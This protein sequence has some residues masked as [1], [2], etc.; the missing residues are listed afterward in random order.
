MDLSII[1]VSYNTRDMLKACLVSVYGETRGIEFEV[2]V[3]DNASTDGSVEMVR[4][5]FPQARIIANTRNAG[6]AGGNNQGMAASHG[7]FFLLL[8]PDTVILDKAITKT[9]AFIRERKDIGVAG[10]RVWDADGSPQYTTFMYPRLVNMLLSATG[11]ASVFRKNRFFGRAQMHWWDH[12]DTREVEVV[13]GC[14]MLV[15]RVVYEQLGGMDERFFMYAEETDWC[16]RMSRAGWKIVF[17]HEAEIVHLI[18]Q[19]GAAAAR[20]M[21]IE[22][23]KSMVK[24]YAKNRGALA[25]WVANAIFV[26][27]DSVRLLAWGL[28][29]L[30]TRAV[31]RDSLALRSKVNAC[32]KALSYHLMGVEGGTGVS[33]TWKRQMTVTAT[34]ALSLLYYVLWLYP[35][36]LLLRILGIP[37][38]ELVILYYH[39]VLPWERAAFARQMDMLLA[40]GQPVALD[41]SE[42]VASHSLALAVTFDDAFENILDSAL[43]ELAARGIPATIFVPSASLGQTAVWQMRDGSPDRTEFIMT[44]DEV[45]QAAGSLISIGSHTLTHQRLAELGDDEA[46][47]QLAQSRA[48]L[49]TLLGSPVRTV[50][51][52]HGS[53]SPRTLELARE[54][55]YTRAYSI[56]LATARIAGDEFLRGRFWGDVDGRSIE[57][58]LKVR[59][60]FSWLWRLQRVKRSLAASRARRGQPPGEAKL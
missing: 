3:V 36:R 33:H 7:D 42:C 15:R 23:R 5:D 21:R 28:K 46:S 54:A 49:E 26:F 56:E 27:G 58:W 44:A 60:A 55:G 51:F 32:L 24:Y 9:L 47:R 34:T 41:V 4:F 6:F 1:I 12:N 57:H 29:F 52:P 2:I 35:K 20:D 13:A 50:A 25:A 11:L 17:Y 31:G 19:S 40:A 8:N 39:G 45:R 14:F 48:E 22:R 10:C 43:P 18:G 38:S 30:C 59:G 16:L 53:Y 37:S